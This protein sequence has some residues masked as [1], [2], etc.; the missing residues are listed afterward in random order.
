MNGTVTQLWLVDISH[1]ADALLDGEAATPR[2][3]SGERTRLDA[4]SDLAVQRL[5]RAAY[6]ARR[7]ALETIFGPTMRQIELPPDHYGRPHLP[8]SYSGSV[9]LAHTGNVALIAVSRNPRIGVD[10]ETSRAI[11]MSPARRAIIESAAQSLSALPLPEDPQARFLQAWTRLEALAKA[12][13]HGIGHLLTRIGA[14]GQPSGASNPAL[15]SAA[16]T[17]ARSHGLHIHDLPLGPSLFAALA[18]PNNEKPA[19]HHWPAGLQ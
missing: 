19:I 5:R 16:A 10:L 15:Q 4:I 6:I 17:M 1:A 18:T 11:R 8:A 14:V 3:A 7:L 9:S 12:D 2:L 13:G